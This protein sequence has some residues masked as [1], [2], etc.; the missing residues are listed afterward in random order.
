LCSAFWWLVAFLL[1]SVLW[2]AVPPWREEAAW[3]ALLGATLQEAARWGWVRGYEAVESSVLR[4]MPPDDPMSVND[5]SVAL[6]SGTGWALVHATVVFGSGVEQ[7]SMRGGA[8]LFRGASSDSA[9]PAEPAGCLA[10]PLAL[11]VA[12][13]AAA[14][15]V[16][17]IASMV[18]TL[19]AW[20]RRSWLRGAVP[21]LAR[22]AFTG[23]SLATVYDPSACSIVLPVEIALVV[24]VS[25]WAAAVVASPT[26]EAALQS[27]KSMLERLE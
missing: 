12:I 9:I 23:I 27:R 21:V 2:L 25:A 22:F 3:G 13:L 14:L 8:Y 11:Y 1:S 19:D 5:L 6:A 7:A 18:L 4:A 17:D 20:R 24:A 16:L 15:S 10:T 26:Y